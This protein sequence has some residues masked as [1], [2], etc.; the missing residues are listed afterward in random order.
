[1]GRGAA[2]ASQRRD[3]ADIRKRSEL[4][5]FLKTRRARI[6]PL[7]AGFPE[8]PR[9]RTEG[10]RREE[11]AMLADVSVTWYT[12][13]E[14]GRPLNVSAETLHNVARALR[15]NHAETAHVF[16][17]ADCPGF[18]LPKGEAVSATVRAMLAGL[19]PN[20]AYLTN[21]CWDVLAWS[22]AARAG[23]IDYSALH[24]IERNMIFDFFAN[25]QRRALV[26]GWERH[27]RRMI[28]QFRVSYG[29]HRDDPR[30]ADII[31]RCLASSTDFRTWWTQHEVEDRHPGEIEIRHPELGELA[32]RFSSF[33]PSDAGDIRL[34]IYTPADAAGRVKIAR[35]LSKLA[36]HK[37]QTAKTK[38]LE[39]LR[40]EG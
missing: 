22:E 27:A 12:F 26:V 28:G 14:Q 25:P 30:F 35:A 11:V 31:A 18:R 40:D 16:A 10:L 20:P 4:A 32:F 34:T 13:L 5:D 9:R 17:L 38:A 2:Q 6:S 15:L 36:K 21:H 3:M 8:R 19:G 39:P 33:G 37:R 7:E 24:A 23:F 1:M 29:R